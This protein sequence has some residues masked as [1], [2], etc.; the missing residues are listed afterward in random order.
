MKS[1]SV[2]IHAEVEDVI[3][4]LRLAVQIFLVVNDV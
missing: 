2:N 4:I 3:I 1:M